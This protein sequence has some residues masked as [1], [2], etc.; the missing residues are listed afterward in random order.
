VRRNVVWCISY[1]ELQAAV[2][3]WGK[4]IRICAFFFY[5]FQLLLYLAASVASIYSLIRRVA[6]RIKRK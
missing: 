3:N 4:S 5:N 2:R 6:C 1:C